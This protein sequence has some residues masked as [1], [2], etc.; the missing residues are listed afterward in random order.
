[1]RKYRWILVLVAILIA[2]PVYAKD[3]SVDELRFKDIESLIMKESPAIQINKNARGNLRDGIA[4]LEDA[5]DGKRDLEKAIS[6]ID[7]AIDEMMSVVD[8]MRRGF[9]FVDINLP[10]EIAGDTLS[11]D[12]PDFPVD[13]DLPDEIPG[14]SSIED[15]IYDMLQSNIA[16]LE[17]NRAM[18]KNQLD[19]L[20][21]IPSQKMELEKTILQLE[22]ADQAIV[23]GAENLYLGHNALAREIDSMVETLE[24]LDNQIDIMLIQEEI[25]MITSLDLRGLE[26]QREQLALAIK[27]M[28]TQLEYLI[29]ELNLM[30][31]QDFDTDLVL[32]DAISIDERALSRI[33][34]RNDLRKAKRNSYA[35]KVKDY[36]Y[37]IKDH[38]AW[39]ASRYGSRDE[40][41]MADRDLDSAKI[42]LNQEEKNV[43][44]AFH[45]S[46]ENVQSK[47]DALEIEEK[48]LEYEQELYQIL[49]I[50][51]ELGMVSDMEF[52]QGQA[53][54]NSKINTFLAAEQELFQTWLGYEALLQG[55]NFQQ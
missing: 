8:K 10:D 35:I 36:D 12:P 21:K 33:N 46:Y 38:D 1:M 20:E 39:W 53:D 48:T 14:L 54:F 30:L 4:A 22:M 55:I 28:E 17:Q 37:E 6:G 44:L 31:G 15:Q 9:D 11:D 41:R 40:R 26:N 13:I 43:E 16:S 7:D 24:I 5:E 45:N 23:L 2:M 19:A 34:Y 47:I 42:E 52:R 3:N 27:T 50:K 25:G 32:E 49:E 51:Y 18:L 29:G